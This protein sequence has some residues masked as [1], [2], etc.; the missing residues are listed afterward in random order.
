MDEKTGADLQRDRER[1]DSP[2]TAVR[3][4]VEGYLVDLHTAMP[5]IV[6][7]FDVETQTATVQPT[8]QRLFIG[9]G[10]R[11]LPPCVNV[12]VQ[13][14]GWG[15]YVM[16]FPVAADDE[17]LLVFNERA[18]DFWWKQGGVQ[19]PAERRL[20]DLSDAFALM[21]ASSIPRAVPAFSATDVEIRR[22]DGTGPKFVLNGDGA[23]VGGTAG[24]EAALMGAKTVAYLGEMFAAINS[25]PGGSACPPVPA[26]LLALLAR[27]A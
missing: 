20:H 8:L 10:W 13:F 25:K 14:P 5:G 21:G 26:D 11:D 19:K 7:S 3:Q 1:E 27:V 23:F 24:A 12:P 16:T 4:I 6:R 22:R 17:C 18:I 9:V 15:P 2:E